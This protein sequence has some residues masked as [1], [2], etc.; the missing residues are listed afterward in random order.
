MAQFRVQDMIRCKIFRLKIQAKRYRFRELGRRRAGGKRDNYL[1][2]GVVLVSNSELPGG[3]GRTINQ[4]HLGVIGSSD[5]IN[6]ILDLLGII[7]ATSQTAWQEP[8][9][10]LI[11]IGNNARLVLTDPKGKN[12]DGFKWHNFGY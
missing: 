7:A 2:D 5:G 3:N 11:V 12:Q 4:T 1:G 10:A 9:T 8:K 6:Q